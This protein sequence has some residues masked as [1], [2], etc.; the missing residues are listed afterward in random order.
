MKQTEVIEK[1]IGENTF[2]IRP[3]GAFIAANISGDLAAIITPMLGAL[4]PL[5]GNVS[6]NATPESIAS[7]DFNI[8]D[9]DVD[10]AL[11]VISKALSGISGQHFESMM[12]KLL[13]QHKNVSV[14]GPITKGQAKPLD[15][16]MANEVFCGEL[17][18]M[19]ILCFEVIKA[20]FGGFFRKLGARF[21]VLQAVLQKM[22]Q[23]SEGSES[24][25]Q[26]DFQNSN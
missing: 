2:Y 19:F 26:P 21:G 24:S 14:E 20:N 12:K 9:M 11:P 6:D 25:M 13:I 7:G 17:Q 3:F 16:D 8:M 22:T 5:V 4:G 18:D 10:K 23:S 15:Y 1:K